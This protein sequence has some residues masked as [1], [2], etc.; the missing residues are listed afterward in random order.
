MSAAEI[1]KIA[2][3]FT[4]KQLQIEEIMADK[5]LGKKAKKLRL[6]SL[7]LLKMPS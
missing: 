5:S 4:Q 1:E 6:L 7:V 2:E 3:E